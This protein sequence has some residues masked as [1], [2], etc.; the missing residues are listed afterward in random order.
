MPRLQGCLRDN[1]ITFYPPPECL[2]QQGSV[3]GHTCKLQVARVQC[4][5]SIGIFLA[6]WFRYVGV[7]LQPFFSFQRCSI[8]LAHFTSSASFHAVWC[9]DNPTGIPS[10]SSPMGIIIIG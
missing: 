9:N 3:L 5:I 7:A 4:I 1:T 6:R 8:A 10:E 2:L